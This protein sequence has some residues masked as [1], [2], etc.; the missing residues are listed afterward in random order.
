MLNRYMCEVLTDMR[1]LGDKLNASTVNQYKLVMP[2]LIEEVQVM[3]NKMEAA[4]ADNADVR[5][6]LKNIKKLEKQ[7][8]KLEEKRDELGGSSND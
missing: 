3:G 6:Y 1:N 5:R 2:F 8:V 4:L 7:I